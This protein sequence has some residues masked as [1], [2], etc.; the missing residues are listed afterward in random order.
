MYEMEGPQPVLLHRLP[1]ALIRRMRRLLGASNVFN[2]LSRPALPNRSSVTPI[3]LRRRFPVSVGLSRFPSTN[4]RA[5]RCGSSTGLAGVA[6]GL[7]ARLFKILF[8]GRD[9][10]Q[11]C[12]GYP[13]NPAS[14]TGASTPSSTSSC[15]GTGRAD[16]CGHA[17]DRPRGEVLSWSSCTAA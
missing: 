16:A 15:T 7:G 6:Q 5:V 8:A 4:L 10:P 11:K 17:A 2:V 14:S 1:I 13:Q 9:G 3:N 12:L